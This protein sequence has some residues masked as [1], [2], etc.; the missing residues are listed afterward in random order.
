MA[1]ARSLMILLKNVEDLELVNKVIQNS[2][3]CLLSVLSHCRD[4]VFLSLEGQKLI[5]NLIHLSTSVTRSFGASCLQYHYF[6]ITLLNDIRELSSDLLC[7]VFST[8]IGAI[9]LLQLIVSNYPFYSR[10]L[11][12]QL[13]LKSCS[14]CVQLSYAHY[15]LE[16]A[17][18][19]SLGASE[20]DKN[21]WLQRIFGNELLVE[22]E[23]KWAGFMHTSSNNL[24][25]SVLANEVITEKGS[26]VHELMTSLLELETH[27]KITIVSGFEFYNREQKNPDPEGKDADDKCFINCE[28]RTHILS[29]IA[30]SMSCYSPLMIC[31]PPSCGKSSLVMH[32]AH[33]I[34]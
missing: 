4:I 21:A 7:Q 22:Y 8:N 32:V 26:D 33:S 29:S 11:S 28:E 20:V 23:V 30:S 17:K 31:G 12:L 2:K 24:K 27:E 5:P 34:G 10:I 6:L 1:S 13:L 3:G 15:C 19:F 16:L 18:L 25:A 9:S 14:Q